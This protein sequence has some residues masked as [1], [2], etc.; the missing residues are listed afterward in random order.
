MKNKTVALL[1]GKRAGMLLGTCGLACVLLL[2]GANA[3]FAATQKTAEGAPRMVCVGDPLPPDT[4]I[5]ARMYDQSQCNGSTSFL[6]AGLNVE[7]VVPKPVPGNTGV[8]C[9]SSPLPPEDVV[10]AELPFSLA[11]S[12]GAKEIT[13]AS[14]NSVTVCQDSPIPQG[15]RQTGTTKNL[16][17]GINVLSPLSDNALILQP[18][19]VDP[20]LSQ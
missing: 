20:P 11:C 16:S 4:V 6:I 10:I 9:A 1:I 18:Q 19:Q 3:A 14:G 2:L 8:V 12:E 7:L 5:I 15:Y 13:P 17:C